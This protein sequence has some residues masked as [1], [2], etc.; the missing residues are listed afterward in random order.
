[1]ATTVPDNESDKNPERKTECSVRRS[2]PRHPLRNALLLHYI[3]SSIIYDFYKM[4]RAR[5]LI[6]ISARH[7][8]RTKSRTVHLG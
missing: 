5:S 4:D 8:S 1:M 7:I 2:A 3:I 6:A